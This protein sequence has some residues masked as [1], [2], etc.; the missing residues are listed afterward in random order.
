M[1]DFENLTLPE[2]QQLHYQVEQFLF[3][4]ASLLDAR[5]Y[6]DW[7]ALLAEDI[8]YWMPIRRTTTSREIENE[9]TAPGAMAFFDDDL[10]SVFIRWPN[11]QH[12]N[13]L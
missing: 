6:H 9:F 13:I 11:K 2:K 12:F 4:E 5:Q 1:S 7:L 10:F 3:H 8:H